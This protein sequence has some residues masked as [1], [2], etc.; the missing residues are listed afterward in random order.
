MKAKWDRVIAHDPYYNPNL[1]RASEDYAL[2]AR[3]GHSP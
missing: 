2:R 1:T 3:M